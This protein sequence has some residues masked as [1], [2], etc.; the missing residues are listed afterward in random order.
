MNKTK[1]KLLSNLKSKEY[2]IN[3]GRIFIKIQ[4]GIVGMNAIL[5]CGLILTDN[6]IQPELL[7]KYDKKGNNLIIAKDF[8]YLK[9]EKY[10]NF[11][12]K[13]FSN[14]SKDLINK[15][16]N[17]EI[18][19]K[20][21]ELKS[22]I[23]SSQNNINNNIN[24][25]TNN[26]NNEIGSTNN[27]LNQQTKVIEPIISSG[28]PKDDTTHVVNEINIYDNSKPDDEENKILRSPKINIDNNKTNLVLF[29][30]EI[31][32][33]KIN[34]I[35]KTHV[36]FVLRLLAF[37][38]KLYDKIKKSNEFN[39][40]DITFENGYMINHQII[41][42]YKEFYNSQNLKQ[43]IKNDI[44]LKNI[45]LKYKGNN[46]YINENFVN[47]F[48]IDSLKLPLEYIKEIDSKDIDNF[49][50]EIGNKE[51]YRPSYKIYKIHLNKEYFYYENI[52]LLSE[53]LGK[54]LLSKV[55][56]PHILNKFIPINFMIANGAIYLKLNDRIFYGYLNNKCIFIPEIIIYFSNEE[57]FNSFMNLL[58]FTKINSILQQAKRIDNN[59][60]DIGIYNN[61]NIKIIILNNKNYTIPKKEE[62]NTNKQMLPQQ[63]MKEDSYC[64]RGSIYNNMNNGQNGQYNQNNR[65]EI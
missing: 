30:M 9:I 14:D 42:K 58:K 52:A 17:N 46:E 32:K 53:S 38:D 5:I 37:E 43:L 28:Q 39:T 4:N 22:K 10:T 62:I 3:E 23:L 35:K 19:G 47:N 48:V 7:L 51:L 24:N 25:N 26:I 50:N 55:N 59:Y 33:K 13:R 15:D 31:Q 36:E 54:L 20:I 11:K 1:Y 60:P 57:E 34:E 16:K 64:F 56:D 18:I 44:N 65:K 45:Y 27:N 41:D 61:T 40:M 6:H 8:D 2:L 63:Q 49:L 29:Q 21:Y 12:D